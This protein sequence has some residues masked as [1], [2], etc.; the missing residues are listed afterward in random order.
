MNQYNLI[1][2]QTSRTKKA[3][4]AITALFAVVGVCVAAVA[5]SSGRVS[6]T[7]NI[8]KSADLNPVAM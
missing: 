7:S 1:P 3:I 4:I 6:F 5:V 8:Y 2:N